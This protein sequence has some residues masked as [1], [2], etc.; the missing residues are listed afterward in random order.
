MQAD[1]AQATAEQREHRRRLPSMRG[2]DRGLGHRDAAL[3]AKRLR[4]LRHEMMEEVLQGADVIC[5]TCV[6]AGGH[7]ALPG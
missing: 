1:I 3:M 2:R 5:A 6:G 4:A 7:W